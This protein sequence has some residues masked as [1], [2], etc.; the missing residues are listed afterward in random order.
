MSIPNGA[1]K[2]GMAAAAAGALIACEDAAPRVR[3]PSN[4]AG[5]Y[6]LAE[7][8][9]Q[10]L[11]HV[12]RVSD[13]R[14]TCDVRLIREVLVLQ[15]DGEYEGEYEGSTRCDGQVRPESTYV[16][17]YYGTFRLHGARG[18]TI[19]LVERGDSGV[20][21]RGVLKGD[22][23]RVNYEVLMEPRRTVRLRYV[24]QNATR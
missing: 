17:R 23:M 10:R 18:D 16:D 6:V 22:E 5:E 8:N 12:L 24:R 7:R 15:A 13:P 9:G 19:V 1:A 21:Q 20:R 3:T 11:P 2:I 14:E 4:V